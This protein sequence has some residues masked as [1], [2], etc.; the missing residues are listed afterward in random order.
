[1]SEEEF[2]AYKEK[3]KH[4]RKNH[5]YTSWANSKGHECKLIGP[6]SMCFC[7][8]RYKDH[9]FDNIENKNVHCLQKKCACP[10]FDHIPVCTLIMR[11]LNRHQMPVQAFL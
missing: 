9:A 1:M 10:L 4:A 6:D 2:E 11:W 8:H 3:V 5:L 7:N